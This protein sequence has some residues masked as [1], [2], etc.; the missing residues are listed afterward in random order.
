MSETVFTGS[1]VLNP[2]KRMVDAMI[3]AVV[4]ET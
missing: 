4:K 3:V 1:V 2:W